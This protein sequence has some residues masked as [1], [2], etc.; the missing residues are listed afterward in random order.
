MADIALAGEP[1]F[2]FCDIVISCADLFDIIQ[3]FGPAIARFRQSLEIVTR[4]GD[5][6]RRAQLCVHMGRFLT[7]AKL[8]KEADRFL[9]DAERIGQRLNLRPTLMRYKAARGLWLADSGASV[10]E[11]LRILKETVNEIRAIE[12]EP[13]F[14]SYDLLDE[15]MKPAYTM[16]RL[17]LHCRVL[18]DCNDAARLAGDEGAIKGT[19]AELD[20]LLDVFP[21]Y[22]PHFEFA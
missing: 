10:S 18:L 11:G 5:E 9:A 8:Y 16:G 22:A 3:R 13:L 17:P 6:T 21:G 2:D 4:L 7:Y 14:V 1:G 15:K 12:A 20:E 19:L